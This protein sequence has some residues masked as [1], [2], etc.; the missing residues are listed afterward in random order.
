MRTGGGQEVTP[1]NWFGDFDEDGFGNPEDVLQSDSQPDGYVSNNLDCDDGD[2]SIHP[3][4]SEV[5]DGLDNNCNGIV[6][7][8]DCPNNDPP[9][10]CGAT[11]GGPVVFMM[12][13]LGFGF[14][15]NRIRGI[16]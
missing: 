7:E 2:P 14:L 16:R 15:R 5:C 4:A 13:L 9:V 11:G 10:C 8:V 1:V 12:F 6:D 3:N